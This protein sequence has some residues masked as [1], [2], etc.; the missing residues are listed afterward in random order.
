MVRHNRCMC[1][2]ARIFRLAPWLLALGLAGC[3][4]DDMADLKAYVNEVKAR[5]KGV[6]EP[7]P[8]VKTV[9]P[10]A[11]KSEDL[12]DPFIID[13][14]SQEPEEEKVE[15]GIRPDTTRARE[16]LESYELDSLRM[17]G[18]VNQ[19]ALLWGLVKANDGTI[20][21]VRVGNYMGKNYGKIINIKENMIE[22]VEIF[23]DSPGAWRE[24]KASLDLAEASGGSK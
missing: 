21:R 23:A 4:N 13:E 17:V 16:E 22:L 1:N 9:E 14:K 19:Q 11:F 10:F 8:E 24:R 12:R 6:V 20:H 18:T 7:L 5:H 2:G 15:S 3:G